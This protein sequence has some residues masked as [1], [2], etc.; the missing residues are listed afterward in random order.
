M[1]IVVTSK[2]SYG[3]GVRGQTTILHKLRCS[4]GLTCDQYV[5]AE[6][7]YSWRQEHNKSATT[8]DIHRRTGFSLDEAMNLA[9][10]L[11]EDGIIVKDKTGRWVATDRW[12]SKFRF[13]DDF[14]EF[15][16]IWKK[17][18]NK[19]RAKQRY[20]KVRKM[21]SK[22]ELHG[23][24]EKVV[25]AISDLRYLMNAEKWLDPEFEHWKDEII[26]SGKLPDKPPN[27][28]FLKTTD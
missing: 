26:K 23:Q 14:E 12:N 17:K 19:K 5:L 20:I 10:F 25:A 28:D 8:E 11:N 24:A 9:E 18:G 22:G 6:F 3:A 7:I 16:N 2:K 1:D 4:L 21:I 27:K 13:D 15:W